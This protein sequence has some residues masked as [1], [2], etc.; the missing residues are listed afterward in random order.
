MSEEDA[1]I[2]RA[3]LERFRARF[4]APF[5]VQMIELFTAQGHERMAEAEAGLAAHDARAVAAAAHAIKSSAGN[6]G[7]APLLMAAAA[8]EVS[9]RGELGHDV[10]ESGVAALRREFE[11]AVTA[12]DGYRSALG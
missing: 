8:L 7:A 9:A 10:L 3:H 1:R 12:L 6:L 11:Q 4:G 2:D 5:I